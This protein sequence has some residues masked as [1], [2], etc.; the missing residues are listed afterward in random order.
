MLP[1]E[2]WTSRSTSLKPLQWHF[3]ATD[4]LLLERVREFG[5]A[6]DED[7]LGYVPRSKNGNVDAVKQQAIQGTLK[8]QMASLADFVFTS[9]EERLLF[10][11]T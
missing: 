9:L 5:T 7:A 8:R 3:D 11:K 2:A 4:A 1:L 6:L 10:L